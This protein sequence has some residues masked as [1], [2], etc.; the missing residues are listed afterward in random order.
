MKTITLL[1]ALLAAVSSSVFPAGIERWGIFEL[2]FHERGWE[3]PF[4]DVVIEAVFTSPG[5]RQTRVAGFYD[6]DGAGG[7]EGD[8]FKLRFSPGETGTWSW[9]IS[10]NRSS[11]DGRSGSFECVNSDR[12]GPLR[13]DPSRPWYLHWADGSV[14]FESGAND[15]ECFLASGFLTQEERYR[16]IDYLAG[17]GADILYM[18]MVNAG[19][20]DGGP[21]M[22]VTPWTG[23]FDR[24][25]FDNICLLFMNRLEGVIRRLGERGMVAHLVVYLDDCGQISRAISSAQEEMLFRYFCSRFGAFPNIVWNLA[26][27]YEECF[28][29]T[30]CV[31]RAGWIKKYDPLG[32]PVTVHG[33]SSDEFHFAGRPDFD[34]TAMQ[35]NYTNPD[36]LNA[37]T[38]KLRLQ[39]ASA[40][41]PIPVS[42]IEWT[43]IAPEQADLARRGMWAIAAGG[44]VYQV[45]NKVDSEPMSAE[46]SRWE[47][48]WN[49][50]AVVRRVMESLPLDRMAPDNRITSRGYCLAAPGEAYLVYLPS[51]GEFTVKAAARSKPYSA[52][53]IDPRTG[54]RTPAG[55]VA[56]GVG[57][58]ATPS[59][60]DWALLVK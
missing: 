57:K 6:G 26:E 51:G 32:H 56:T 14:F 47:K 19:P 17:K 33:L 10:S 23:G 7:V 4:R 11:L 49:Y 12:C 43:P 42:I 41:R 21:E 34:L 28:D 3:N 22:K 37:V 40:G 29:S 54:S 44:G 58:F 38:R 36:S 53:W 5:G 45:F 25:E 24:P 52:L 48:V 55:S 50:A 31:T 1:T 46:F 59:G 13:Y 9:K 39:V 35:F 30:W 16:G 18:G 2:T 8:V 60:E 20:G 15:P 27:E